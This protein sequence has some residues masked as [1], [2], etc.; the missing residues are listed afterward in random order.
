MYRNLY[1]EIV[2]DIRIK[3]V[4]YEDQPGVLDKIYEV[5]SYIQLRYWWRLKELF[6]DSQKIGGMV[7]MEKE[8]Q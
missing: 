6:R 3:L 2:E 1:E 8:K 4:G 7:I 5:V